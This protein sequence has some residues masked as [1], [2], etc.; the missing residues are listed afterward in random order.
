MK[1]MENTE[2]NDLR[3]M[4]FLRKSVKEFQFIMSLAYTV[5]HAPL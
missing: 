5:C 4:I 3:I 1:F 2:L